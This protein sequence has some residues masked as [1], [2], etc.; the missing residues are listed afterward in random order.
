MEEVDYSQFGR[1][2]VDNVNGISQYK[3]GNNEKLTS[4]YPNW[5]KRGTEE[6]MATFGAQKLREDSEE[7]GVIEELPMRFRVRAYYT[8]KANIPEVS[9]RHGVDA[10]QDAKYYIAEYVFNYTLN[11][12][13]PPVT[14]IS[15]VLT[16][17][18]VESVTYYSPIGQSSRQPFDGVNIIVT[19]YND[20]T[21]STT[22]VIK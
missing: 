15:N 5:T 14:G 13:T 7:T 22:K 19:R 9:P 4:F 17:R 18:H 21:I 1:D 3:L 10:A 11:D 12:E 16:E 8:R 6:V 20:G 2:A